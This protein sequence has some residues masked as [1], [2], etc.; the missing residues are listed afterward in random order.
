MS[1]DFKV[2]VC[3]GCQITEGSKPRASPHISTPNWAGKSRSSQTF[4]LLYLSSQ[5]IKGKQ[6]SGSFF[7]FKMLSYTQ[8]LEKIPV[9]NGLHKLIN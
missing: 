6:N 8:T 1:A 4:N 7:F 3:S 5:E 2:S 9:S